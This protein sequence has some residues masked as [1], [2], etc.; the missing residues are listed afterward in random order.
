MK[1]RVDPRTGIIVKGKPR[2]VPPPPSSPKQNRYPQW[3]GSANLPATPSPISIESLMK[4]AERIGQV[5]G[6]IIA[7]TLTSRPFSTP[8]MS[9]PQTTVSAGQTIAIDE[10]IID[11]GL[12]STKELKKGE[13]S[14]ILAHR[15]VDQD[16]QLVQSANKLRAL[17]QGK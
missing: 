2:P 13:G 14:A 15:D 7:D 5:T 8:I 12:D 3:Q 10:S 6:K 1:I 9:G 16:T 4:I 17:K 11:V